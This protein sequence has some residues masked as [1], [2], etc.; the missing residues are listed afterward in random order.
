MRWIDMKEAINMSLQELNRAV[1]DKALWTS[2]IHRIDRSQ[3]QLSSTKH[4][5]LNQI[6]TQN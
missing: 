5:C 6:N 3:G 2:F 4:M 1:E